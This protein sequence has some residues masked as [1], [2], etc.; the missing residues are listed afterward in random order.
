MEI[1]PGKLEINFYPHI[2]LSATDPRKA[3]ITEIE[4]I[5]HVSNT[6]IWKH[7]SAEN[8]KKAMSKAAAQANRMINRLT[9]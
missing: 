6:V 4:F 3:W 9:L 2:D 8:R 7:Y 5:D 1:I